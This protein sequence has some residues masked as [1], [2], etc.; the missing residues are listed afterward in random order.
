LQN[1]GQNNGDNLHKLNFETCRMFRN[2]EREYL[3]DK[4][5]NHGTNNENKNII[6][7]LGGVNELKKEYQPRIDII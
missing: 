3:K 5:N 1:P 2:K 7:F 6:D 4:I